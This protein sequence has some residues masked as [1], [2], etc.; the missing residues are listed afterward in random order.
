MYNIIRGIIW[1]RDISVEYCS[2]LLNLFYYTVQ[3]K[4]KRHTTDKKKIQMSAPK[5]LIHEQRGADKSIF[6]LL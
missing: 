4:W 6:P 3:K 1:T 2:V 5:N